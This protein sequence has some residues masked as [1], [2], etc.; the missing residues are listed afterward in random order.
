MREVLER[1]DKWDVGEQFE[2][3]HLGDIVVGGHVDH[4]TVDLTSVYYDTPERDLQAHGILLR[5]RDGDDD[6]GWQ[7]KTPAT[8]GR[9]ELRWALTD[10]PPEA[11]TELLT[12]ISLGKD[13]TTVA[14][15]HTVRNWYRIRDPEAE[16]PCAE[17]AD[18]SVHGWSDQR[19]LAW[20]EIEVEH[21]SGTR[22]FFNRLTDR[23]RSAGARPS[24]YESKLAHVLP[25]AP[26]AEPVSPAGRALASYLGAQIDAVV[27]GDLGL[28]RGQDPIHDTRVA[29]RRLRSTL[30]V[31]R[32]VLDRSAIGDFDGELRWFAALLG[33]VRDCQVQH[34][35]FTAALDE[36][37]EELVLGPVRS[38]VSNELQSIEL[39]ARVRVRDAMDS[40]RYLAIMSVL[41][42]WRSNPP[43]NPETTKG[44]LIRKARRAGRKADR[45]LTAALRNGDDALLHRARKAAKR[46]RYAAELSKPI[47]GA[48]Q[49]KRIKKH[50]K[51]IQ[52]VLGDHHDT[53]LASA[54]LRRMAVSA[55]TTAGENGFTYGLLFSREQQIAEECRRQARNLL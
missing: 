49:T 53:V 11:L 42:S 44:Q 1:E 36:F 23:L 4:H 38:H 17:V 43:I 41:R 2:L 25:R 39:P 16:Q 34:R 14:T 13:L 18:D 21:G 31:F 10:S 5:R 7:L 15:I 28:R 20:R 46:A 37:P 30:R 35:R 47:G 52:S 40:P 27:A 55:G 8:G 54:A 26:V 22:S 50:Y 32:K 24:R 51:G 3:P 6:A 19:S 33:D 29:I 45:R 12:G 48:K 9:T